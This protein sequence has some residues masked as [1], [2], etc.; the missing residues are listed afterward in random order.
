LAIYVALIGNT[1][2]LTYSAWTGAGVNGIAYAALILPVLAAALFL[3]WRMGYLAAVI[4]TLIGLLLFI[5]GRLG[6]LVNLQRPITDVMAWFANA[7][8]FFIAA[9]QIGVSLRQV[10]R[11]LDQAQ[12]ETTERQQAEAEL[13]RL[14]AELEERIAERTA[15]LAA[16]EERYR[17]VSAVSSDYVF[18]TTV[19]PEGTLATNWVGGAFE[20]LSGYALDEYAAKGGWRAALHPDDVGIDDHDMDQLRANQR[21]KSELRTITKNGEVKWVRVYADPVWD[22]THNRL[23][24]IY[25]AVQDITDRKQAEEALRAS[26]R[27]FRTLVEQLPAI[28]YT[29]DV[30]Q[31]GHTIY[32]SPQV[33]T[34]LGYTPEQWM[35]GELEFWLTRILPEDRER[36]LAEFDRCFREGQPV[37]SEYRMLA[38]DGRVVWFH[39]RATRLS[40][41]AGQPDTIQG[42]MID[43]TERKQVEA[44]LLRERSLLQALMDNIPDTIYFKDRASRFTRINR[45]Q[46]QLMGLATPADA[47]G[48]TDLDLQPLPLAKTFY[49][50]EQDMMQTGLPIIDRLEYNPTRAGDPRWLSATKA[51]IRNADGQIEGL[52]GISRDITEYKLNKLNEQRESTR[53]AMLEKVIELGKVVTHITDLTQC[54][55]EIHQSVQKGLGFDRVG[56]F[57]YDPVTRKVTG[58]FGTSVTGEIEDTSWFSQSVDEQGGWQVPLSDP[59]GMQVLEE[60]NQ[61]YEVAAENE[62][63]EVKQHV[64]QA[65]WAGEHPV[66]LIAADNVVTQR[67]F[68]KEQLEALQLFAGYAG[69]AIENARWNAEL[70]QRVA[71]RTA[72]L[73]AANR[74]LESLAY[75]IAHDLRTP[76]RAINGFAAILQETHARQ[77]DA[78]ALERLEIIRQS[79]LQMGELVDDLLEYMRLAR[80][81]L[82]RQTVKVQEIVS[83][84]FNDLTAD[85]AERRIELTIGDL[86][87]CSAD[88]ALLRSVFQQLIANALKFTRPRAVAQIEISSSAVDE[89]PC[90]FVRDNGVGFNMQ[91]SAKIFGA[92][93]RLH[94][95]REFEGTGMGLAIVSRIVQRH[96]G[97]IWAEANED[98]GAA[99]YFTL[100]KRSNL[101]TT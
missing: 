37:Q 7:L 22:E 67:R 26:E 47:I 44:D 54:L 100:G 38:K 88:P 14:N 80:T 46:A 89:G 86:P 17:A 83:D 77:L 48:K 18:S 39:D 1:L 82:N 68:T 2:V 65:A 19:S 28:T 49:A 16:S 72:D 9:H 15:Q 66:A 12:A 78:E 10:D 21:V 90:Y 62:M 63:R 58:T 51:P 76:A 55:R 8:F 87:D 40:D 3:G 45:A 25:G 20:S 53:R 96:G 70:E 6:W 35:D 5:A 91:Y 69:L 32:I 30:K 27:R 23:A 75:A 81:P 74:E 34:L 92:F 71:E 101:S 98:R 13:R 93:Q 31:L 59:H 56:L 99:F 85:Q 52:V 79:G 57:L 24:G 94:H 84:V 64:T 50:E 33:E 43:I 60:Y 97:R 41:S 95:L 61:R 4:A 11:A 42:V 36:A 29:D 73:E